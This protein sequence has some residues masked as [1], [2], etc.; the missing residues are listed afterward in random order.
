MFSQSFLEIYLVYESVG[1]HAMA[2]MWRL[3]FTVFSLQC[4]VLKRVPRASYSG[5][6]GRQISVG[7]GE[8]EREGPGSKL[9]VIGGGRGGAW[10][11]QLSV[12]WLLSQLFFWNSVEGCKS[13]TLSALKCPAFSHFHILLCVLHTNVRGNSPITWLGDNNRAEFN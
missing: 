13:L 9:W 6:R 1:T 12:Q 4:P 11:H 2:H 5:G 7:G 10:A 8:G 3:T